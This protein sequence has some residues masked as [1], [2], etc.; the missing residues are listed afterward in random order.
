MAATSPYA[1]NDYNAVSQ[2]RPYEL[3]INDAFRA[4]SAQSLF[5]E[6]GAA[7]VK[8][9][10]DNALNLKLSLEPNKQI[11]DQY[12]KDAEKQLAKL[13][14]MDLSKP[15]VQRQGFSLFKPLFQDE[16]IMYDDLATRH[17]ENVR[18]DA[19]AFREQN[20]GKGYSD[21]NFQ[22][23]MQG[24]NEFIGSKDRMAGKSAYQNRKDYTPFYDYTED[25]AR[26][27]KDCKPSSIE[28]QSPNYTNGQMSGYMQEVYSKKLSVD[29]AR[30]CLESG[31]SGKA[32]RQL[33]IEGAV[34]YR[35]NPEVLASDTANYLSGVSANLS[36][37]LQQ[38]AA[39][40][41]TLNG[42]TDLTPEQKLQIANQI[43]EQ[44]KTVGE[45][46]DRTNLTVNKLNSGDMSPINENYEGY[47]GNVYSYKKLYKKALASSFEESRNIYKADPV[48]LNAVRFSQDIYLRKMDHVF[49]VSLET[50]RQEHQ[51]Q[52]KMLDLMY[53]S[54][55]KSGKGL[56]P[57]I[58]KDPITGQ[59]ILRSDLMRETPN[60]YESPE[61]DK[62]IYEK[63]T[64][65]VSSLNDQ[66]KSNNLRLYNSLV[67]RAERDSSLRESLMKGF[68]YSDWNK[69]K[70]DTRDNAFSIP[71]EGRTGG[72]Q[73]TPWF[74]SYIS[75]KTSDEDVNKWAEGNMAVNIALNTLNRRIE[76]GEAQV[77]KELG[78]TDVETQMR[79]KF[80]DS[81]FKTKGGQE[82][83]YED[84]VNYA[85]QIGSGKQGYAITGSGLEYGRKQTILPN[86]RTANQLGYYFNGEL[87]PDDKEN[88]KYFKT[89]T[90]KLFPLTEDVNKVQADLT[91]KRAE[92]YNKLGFD[93]EP[94]FFTPNDKGTLVETIKPLFPDDKGKD[95]DIRIL[96]SDFSG[97]VRVAIPGESD[98]NIIE[99]IRAT[100]IGTS[101]EAK[102]G[103]A[104]IKG[105]T[106]NLIN[107]AI[108]NPMI[109]EAA[110]QLSTIGETAAFNATQTG[111]KVPNSDIKVPVYM[112]G[113][114]EQMTIETYKDGNMPLF[115]VYL[116]GSTT[117]TPIVVA[118][119]PYELFEKISRTPI[120]FSKPIK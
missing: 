80:G 31:L 97:G 91:K 48:Q 76:L 86:G 112:R 29:Q 107:Q 13:S 52:M 102:D 19:L 110:Y 38:L 53:G 7:R 72:I 40:K 66:D 3:P 17:Y 43:D 44:S 73:D 71:T 106:Y 55:G 2:F 90:K 6:Q 98:T 22:Y 30:G 108:S 119:N 11:R 111:A 59:I 1:P 88:D 92:V 109:K 33:Q 46:L 28:T 23:A 65:Q 95:K 47:A 67:T 15:D 64:Q 118:S 10:Y 85:R 4:V 120:E 18:N 36:E 114:M 54:D 14:T 24:Y 35:N 21:I 61:G 63:L 96:S 32:Q 75:E 39:K 9:V 104:T 84:F 37:Q 56:T 68:N 82:I 25:F 42:R 62:K 87:I 115:K 89:F 78:L 116:E 34:S 70:A 81:S 51:A 45:E 79:K 94:W 5:W 41:A 27:L 99:K 57:D 105:T 117:N 8:G 113:K 12:I 101:V 77:A 83:K 26:A 16:G 60:L 69:F 20:N 50:M 49:D 74:K 93:K 103:V 58:I 100:G